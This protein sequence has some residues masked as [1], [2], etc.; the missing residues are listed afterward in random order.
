MGA[1][2]H[3]HLVVVERGAGNVGQRI[4]LQQRLGLR[5]HGDNIAGIRHPGGGI[6]NG[7]RLAEWVE[8]G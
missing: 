5:A 8:Y 6:V 3:R 4:E 1:V 7:D 2:E